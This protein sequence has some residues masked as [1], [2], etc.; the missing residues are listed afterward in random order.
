MVA[1]AS[2][3]QKRRGMPIFLVSTKGLDVEG[4]QLVTVERFK[5]SMEY[6]VAVTGTTESAVNSY[7][8]RS[9][10][11]RHIKSKGNDFM[12]EEGQEEAKSGEDVP[13]YPYPETSCY[14]FSINRKH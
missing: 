6:R 4:Y 10:I 12:N 1:A 8:K 14:E 11:N 5:A 2:Y 9:T 13:E 3:H 7:Q